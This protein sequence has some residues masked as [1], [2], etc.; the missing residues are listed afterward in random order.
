MAK[1]AALMACMS[2]LQAGEKLNDKGFRAFDPETLYQLHLL[3]YGDEEAAQNAAVEREQATL[4]EMD[5]AKA[6][7]AS[8]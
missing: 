7:N 3:A 1:R 6:E 2:A 8:A 4:A 5:A